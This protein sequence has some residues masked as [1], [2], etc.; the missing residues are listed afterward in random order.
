MLPI[1]NEVMRQILMDASRGDL[2]LDVS[3][4]DS[5]PEPTSSA[6]EVTYTIKLVNGGDE[7]Q[8]WYTG[9]IA[10]SITDDSSAGTASLERVSDPD[11]Y[12]GNRVY[13]RG[14]LVTY[15]GSVYSADLTTCGNLP[16][17]TDFW[18]VE[19][20]ISSIWLEDGIGYM[21]VKGD[22]ES[23]LNSEEVTF[24]VGE[25]SAAT[26]L[27]GKGLTQIERTITFTT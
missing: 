23:W 8:H 20:S 2:A 10:C 24:D 15:G 1:N 3:P 19:N 27:F 12:D 6:W 16:T 21:K 17:D 9:P 7:V 11:D 5:T 26:E 18:T 22:A 4:D 14:E 13:N 25:N